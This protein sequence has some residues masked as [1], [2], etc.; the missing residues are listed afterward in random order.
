MAG[1]GW[2]VWRGFGPW[3]GLLEE[4]VGLKVEVNVGV[5]VMGEVPIMGMFGETA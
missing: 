1:M 5:R 4:G 3:A 2:M